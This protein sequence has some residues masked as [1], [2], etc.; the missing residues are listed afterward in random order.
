MTS[1]CALSHGNGPRASFRERGV[2]WM[3]I[4]F[5]FLR[6][7]EISFQL[8]LKRYPIKNFREQPDEQI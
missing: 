4:G 1:D 8:P 3:C 5:H 6:T 2:A 7:C